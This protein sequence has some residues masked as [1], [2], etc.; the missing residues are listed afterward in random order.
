MKRYFTIELLH[1]IRVENRNSIYA[2]SN[3]VERT[4]LRY[5]VYFSPMSLVLE[6]SFDFST[7]PSK[8][9]RIKYISIDIL[10]RIFIR[11]CFTYIYLLGRKVC[12]FFFQHE[13]KKQEGNNQHH[14]RYSTD[15]PR[16]SV[17][18][19][20]T[21]SF[22]PGHYSNAFRIPTENSR[23]IYIEVF[24]CFQE[25][26]LPFDP[27]KIFLLAP[28]SFTLHPFGKFQPETTRFSS[29]FLFPTKHVY[30]SFSSIH[31][32]HCFSWNLYIFT[33]FVINTMFYSQL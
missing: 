33:S 10:Y 6:R 24:I 31:T 2:H 29:Y 9:I 28:S 3:E 20:W 27:T 19:I 32:I 5:Y 21:V 1:G 15:P 8:E 12:L 23:T 26:F 7:F 17:S 11:K 18:F 16:V 22:P 4:S 25:N 30:C 14:M 13:R